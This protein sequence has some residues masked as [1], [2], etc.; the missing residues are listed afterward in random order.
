MTKVKCDNC[1]EKHDKMH[2]ISECPDCYMK[3][4]EKEQEKAYKRLKKLI[5][6]LKIYDL[7]CDMI[8]EKGEEEID[9]HWSMVF[10]NSVIDELKQK[11]KE[12]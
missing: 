11:L 3:G 6:E 1:G 5:R 4:A 7:Y 2:I 8:N 9:Q 12:K 10:V